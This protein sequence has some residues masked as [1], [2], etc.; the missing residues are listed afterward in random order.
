MQDNKNTSFGCLQNASNG[1]VCIDTLRVL[2]SC[3]DRDCFEDTRVYLTAQGNSIIQNATNL[4]TKSATS[5]CAFVGVEEVP[6]NNGFYQVVIR[7]YIKVEF[8]V[9]VCGRSRGAV[10]QPVCMHALASVS[11]S[12]NTCVHV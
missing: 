1:T 9:C 7:Y 12:A 6:F 2:D 5:L 8:E 10:C 3:R 11:L 4:R